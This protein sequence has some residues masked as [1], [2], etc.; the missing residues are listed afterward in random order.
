MRRVIAIDLFEGTAWYDATSII[1]DV[2]AG[3]VDTWLMVQRDSVR[4]V[5][6]WA[7]GLQVLRAAANGGPSFHCRVWHASGGPDRP[8]VYTVDVRDVDMYWRSCSTWDSDSSRRTASSFAR[9]R[10]APTGGTTSDKA[11]V[12]A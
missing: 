3:E 5:P 10:G 1:G 11:E 4:V 9:M 12:S 8:T 2:G 6:E 7:D